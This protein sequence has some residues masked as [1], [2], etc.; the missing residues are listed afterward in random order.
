[1]NMGWCSVMN[2]ALID[3]NH[4]STAIL[5]RYPVPFVSSKD[6]ADTPVFCV[7]AFYYLV[8]GCCILDT[9]LKVQCS[10]INSSCKHYKFRHSQT[11]LIYCSNSVRDTKVCRA[12]ILLLT[13]YSDNCMIKE[14][15]LAPH[16]R[17]AATQAELKSL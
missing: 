8:K 10:T 13:K 4:I 3:I 1:V 6:C 2:T 9:T 14:C 17:Q 12:S 15:H 5:S 16:Q 7:E 11:L